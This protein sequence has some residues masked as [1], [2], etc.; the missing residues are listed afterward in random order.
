MKTCVMLV[1][2]TC[3]AMCVAAT[4]S[5]EVDSMAI[6][7]QAR[8]E[9]GPRLAFALEH[10]ARILPT[11]DGRSFYV[12][13]TPPGVTSPPLVVTL[14]GHGSY[15]LDEFPLWYPELTR[16]GYGIVALQW[17]F[18]GGESQERYFSPEQL[19]RNIDLILHQLGARP[20]S[21]LAHGFSRGSANIY[22]VT[23]LDVSSGNHFFAL[24]VANA[25][26]AS[27]DFPINTAIERG[28]FG[29][30]PFESTRWV[31]C[32]GALDANP[33]RDGV[34]GMRET[35][36]WVRRLGGTVELAIEDPRGDHG[37]F[38]RNPANM[39][40]ALDVFARLLRSP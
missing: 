5:P 1:L 35:A 28:A 13:W 26:K 6:F 8:V 9:R 40:A 25:G 37:A 27:S 7:Q 38:H 23:A 18:G 16:R 19:Y 31:T 12:L 10:G 11:P 32:A 34:A 15:A 30:R 33:D 24:T 36:A 4:A 22:G 3:L 39:R 2:L 20:R 17:W 21:A 29:P 14:H